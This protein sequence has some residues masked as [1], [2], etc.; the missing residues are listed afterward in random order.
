MKHLKR[1]NESYN[2]MP[3]DI[4]NDITDIS[5]DIIDD[6]YKIIYHWA[7]PKDKE[8][9]PFYIS[10]Y[11]YIEIQRLEYWNTRNPNNPCPVDIPY[12]NIKDY[13]LRVNNYLKGEGYKVNNY[14]QRRGYGFAEKELYDINTDSNLEYKYSNILELPYVCFPPIYIIEI[15]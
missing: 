11:P 9:I 13:V 5:A 6:G 2:K 12:S 1:Y 7:S 10:K 15:I 4:Q 3:M 8:N 14:Y